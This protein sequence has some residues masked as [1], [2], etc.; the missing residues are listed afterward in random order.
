VSEAEGE[1]GSEMN[2]AD[3]DASGSN[4]FLSSAAGVV[5]S[6]LGFGEDEEMPD[7]PPRANTRGA[8]RPLNPRA[9]R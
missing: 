8:R 6:A 9:R 7:L 3:I 5:V 2:D 1:S 4:S